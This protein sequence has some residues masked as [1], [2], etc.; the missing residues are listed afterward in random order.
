MNFYCL[1]IMFLKAVFQAK[2]SYCVRIKPKAAYKVCEFF[3]YVETLLHVSTSF[4]AIF[5]EVLY[6]VCVTRTHTSV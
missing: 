5:R 6:E 4:A 1:F 2:I 3:I